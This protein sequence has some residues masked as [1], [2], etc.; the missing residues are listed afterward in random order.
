MS[1]DPVQQF[2]TLLDTGGEG[3]LSPPLLTPQ[4]R[5]RSAGISENEQTS[6]EA[7][8]EADH[9]CDNEVPYDGVNQF[10][11]Q[12]GGNQLPRAAIQHRNSPR[13]S[14]GDLVSNH[15]LDPSSFP[16]PVT[17]DNTPYQNQAPSNS[18]SRLT[19][20]SY[21]SREGLPRETQ[22]TG[23][24]TLVSLQTYIS[25]DQINSQG[26]GKSNANRFNYCRSHHLTYK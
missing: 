3:S 9:E 12:S 19:A 8:E 4:H 2:T 25:C 20:D 23:L 1:A 13:L 22:V 16:L 24:V 14:A 21:H 17:T 11:A 5:C 7:T 6:N 26:S 15:P 18:S 10:P